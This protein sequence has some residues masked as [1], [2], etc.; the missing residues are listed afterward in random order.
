MLK[1]ISLILN[2][3]LVADGFAGNVIDVYGVDTKTAARLTAQYAKQIDDVAGLFYQA[4]M[5]NDNL[6]E[7]TRKAN[8][9]KTLQLA[10]TIK[11]K[12]GFLYVNFDTV[13]Y[14]GQQNYYTTVEIVDKNRPDRLRFIKQT[15][16][17]PHLT[18][19]NKQDIISSMITYSTI[20]QELIFNNKMDA[21]IT[22]CPVYHCFSNFTHPQLKPY[23]NVFNDGVKK[24][25]SLI[26]ATLKH[27][28][29][30]ERRGAAIFLI[31]HFTNPHEIMNIL[32][33][34]VN[35]N[36]SLVRNNAIRVISETMRSAHI[37]DV[38][39]L[40]F[41]TLLDSPYETDRNKSLLVL[42]TVAST[43]SAQST[44][45]HHGSDKLLALLK[46]KQPN[47]HEL[48][49]L[50][51]KTMSGKQYGEYDISAWQKW[52]IQKKATDLA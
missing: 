34:Y 33:P 18:H 52:M 47:N 36:N 22:S 29:D 25:K 41:I 45:I 28:A 51:L 44:I 8:K 15:K 37:T 26:L 49:Y 6:P 32:L 43:Q 3:I 40:P 19:E 2:I 48:V 46:L 31:G 42:L 1:I 27:D 5:S 50:I 14:P 20:S 7:Q 10:Q 23:L 13:F 38:D 9:A 17:S 11:Q 35:D 21:Q 30:E 24:Y 16:A 39:L 12:F 4:L